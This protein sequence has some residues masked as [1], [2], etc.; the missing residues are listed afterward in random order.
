VLVGFIGDVH[1]KILHALALVLGW[2]RRSGRRFDLLVQVGDMGAYPDPA[3]TDE[4]TQR[5]LELDPTEAEVSRLVAAEGRLAERL[6]AVRE[7]LVTPMY[8]VRGNHEDFAYLR[9]LSCDEHDTAE[10]DRFGLLRYV[11]EGQV[12][13]LA[14]T[15]VA[16]LG[17]AEEQPGEAGIDRDAYER[18]MRMEPG[19][20][21]VLV[22][23]QGPYGSGTTF[24]GAVAGSPMMSELI[25]R[26]GPR[27]HVAGHLHQL[28]GPRRFGATTYLG[29][30]GLVASPRWQPEARGLQPGCLGVLDTDSR[31]LEPVTDAWLGEFPV[32]L[33]F[34]GWDAFLDS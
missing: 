19:T 6:A 14:G 25:E 32:P 17:G 20:V 26:L 1:G 9:G 23:H 13:D 30:D 18:L 24:R 3:H 2:Q 27:F 21:D 10:V 29:L 7:Q 22:T 4:A 16:F 8:F 33:D 11:P 31:T 28:V 34:E 12:L 5:H 15:R